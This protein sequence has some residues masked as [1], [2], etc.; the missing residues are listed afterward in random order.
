MKTVI[1]VLTAVALFA[2][3]V[4]LRAS[5]M[6]PLTR[7]T[8]TNRSDTWAWVTGYDQKGDH[9]SGG[10][11]CIAPGQEIIKEYRS[12]VAR[13]RF[14]FTTTNCAHPVYKDLWVGFG[15]V[16]RFYLYGNRTEGYRAETAA[17]HGSPT[18]CAYY[19]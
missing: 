3:T 11:F 1:T 4:P 14:E 9:A 19:R 15:A 5:A 13:M 2:A 16:I 12:F 18:Y 8:I 17:C 7:T 10:A 6:P